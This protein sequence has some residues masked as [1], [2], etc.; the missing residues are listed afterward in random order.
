[1]D[2]DPLSLFTPCSRKVE[3]YSSINIISYEKSRKEFLE[4][5]DIVKTE[6]ENDVHFQ[7]IHILDLPILELKPPAEVLIIIL[8]LFSPD[9]VYNFTKDDEGLQEIDP[10][11]DI[12]EIFKEKGITEEIVQKALFWLERF[13]PRLDNRLKLA[14]LPQLSLSLRKNN[15]YNAYITR[16]ISSNLSWL[17]ESEKGIIYKEAS[18][19]ISENCGRTAQPEIVRKIVIPNL[20]NFFKS[21]DH[22]K[23]KEPSLTSDNLGLKTWGS[24]LIL[25]NRLIN[26]NNNYLVDPIIELGSGTGLVGMV[27]AILGHKT[28]LTDLSEI[29]PNLKENIELNKVSAVAE[30]LDWTNPKSFIE[31]YPHEKFNTILIS[32]P[33][34]SPKHPYWVV[35]MLDLFLSHN[36]NARILIQLP[37]RPKYEEEREV[38]WNLMSTYFIEIESELEDG[39]D[40]FGKIKFC[41]KMY[42]RK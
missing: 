35:E 13:C 4:A 5:V 42:I 14:Y 10:D 9:I 7:P 27:S 30:V 29:V 26:K 37:L 36:P 12:E 16:I 34:Y 25:S 33:I 38:L 19:R 17:S 6:I 39:E 1:M 21:S 20:N 18:L 31:K 11:V 22:I 2:F 8:K 3:D 41:F 28:I 40:D 32:D 15:D 23:L 24:S